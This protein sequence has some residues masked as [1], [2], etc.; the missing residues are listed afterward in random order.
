MPFRVALVALNASGGSGISR[1]STMLAHALD[2]VAGEFDDLALV[3]LTTPAG[4][5]AITP[6]SIET[7]VVSGRRRQLPGPYRLVLEQVVL[8]RQ[9]CQLVHFF[10]VSA[11]LLSPR[12]PFVATFHD[13]S[14]RRESSHFG[15]LQRA[16]KLRLYPLALKRAKAVVAVS[17]F[18]R[19]EAVRHFGADPKKVSVVHSGP[20]LTTAPGRAVRVSEGRRPSLLFVGNLT[21]SKNVPFLVR[22]FDRADVDA[23]LVLA[24]RPVDGLGDLEEVVGRSRVA[25][26][27]R[28][29]QSPSDSELEALY[30]GADVFLFPSRYEGFGFPPLEAMARDC[31]VLASD[32]PA[33]REISGGGA[34]LVPLDE[35]S[36]AAQI[37]RLVAERRL[38]DDLRRRGRRAVSR[39]SWQKTAR[40][41]C[42]LFLSVAERGAP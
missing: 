34:L 7:C 9:R 23:E 15:G 14:I 25:G 26:R 3:L 36:W 41:V 42:R 20:G 38:R 40:E 21:A 33:V 13:A 30:A 12:R 1:Y 8:P 31:P 11:P 28:L 27:I 10:D 6:G 35:T 5:D 24:G 16:Y 17:A 4:A 18:A 29:V 22:A 37:R 2:E 39:Y 32:I 19:E